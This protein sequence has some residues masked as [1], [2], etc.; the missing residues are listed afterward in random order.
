MITT[1]HARPHQQSAFKAALKGMP[2][3]KI[4]VCPQC[5]RTVGAGRG[6]HEVQE[7]LSSHRCQVASREALQP[8]TAVPFN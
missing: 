7:I 5:A 6:A 2:L 8:S 4:V 3:N 1:T